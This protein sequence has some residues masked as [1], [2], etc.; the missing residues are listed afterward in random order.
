VRVRAEVLFEISL[1][2]HNQLVL[3]KKSK[4]GSPKL[5][6]EILERSRSLGVYAFE[7]LDLSEP[8]IHN[9]KRSARQQSMEYLIESELNEV[10]YFILKG[11]AFPSHSPMHE[12]KVLLVIK[13]V[14]GNHYFNT[15]PFPGNTVLM[16]KS[17]NGFIAA[18]D[19]RKN[20]I[21]WI[22]AEVGLALY[23]P[24]Q[25]ITAE[26]YFVK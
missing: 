17:E 23:H 15:G 10:D 4:F 26:T 2:I 24:I 6:A 5:A 16:G 8:E 14:N 3:I 9:P 18:I 1:Y 20:S 12:L 21:D 11:W 19:K 22:S 25:G 7:D 13:D